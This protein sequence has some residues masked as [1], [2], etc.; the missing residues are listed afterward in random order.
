MKNLKVGDNVKYSR[1]WLRNT[2]I[3]TGEICFAS[4]RI[5][6]LEPLG[7]TNTLAVIDWKNPNIPDR[8]LTSNLVRADKLHIERA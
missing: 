5:I 3:F 6:A 7:K 8:V 1:E 2:G 4:G